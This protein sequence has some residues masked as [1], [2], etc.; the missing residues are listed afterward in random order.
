MKFPVAVLAVLAIASVANGADPSVRPPTDAA[1]LHFGGSTAKAAVDT[2]VLMGPGSRYPYSG[3]F[4]TI[5]PRPLSQGFLAD[6]WVSRDLNALPG[7]HWH[8]D[9][10]GNP[11]TGYGVWCGTLSFPSC[12]GSDPSG[13]YGNNWHDVLEF[14]KPV[15]GAATVRVQAKLRY[16]TEPGYDFLSLK[17]RT[18]NAP[19]FESVAGGQ[20]QAWDGQ[21]TV[22][23]DR[24]FTYTNAELVGGT[25]IAIAFI[26]D[27]ESGWSDEDCY[28]PTAGAAA[29]DDITVT[30]DDGNVTVYHKDFEDGQVGPDWNLAPDRVGVGDFARVWTRL[31]DLDPCVGNPTNQVAFLDDGLVVP[32]TGG[33]VGMAGNDYGTP[34]GWTVNGTGGMLGHGHDLR[35]V[36]ESPVMTLPGGDIDGVTLSFDVY[37][38]EWQTQD[39]AMISY[40]WSIRS[41]AGGD[42]S[43]AAWVDRG[44]LPV[45]G[46]AYRRSVNPVGDLLVP[47]ATQLQVRLAVWQQCAMFFCLGTEATPAPYF[48]NVRVV[49]YPS[50]GPRI[51]AR[52]EDLANDGFPAIGA[53]DLADPGRNSVRFDMADNIAYPPRMLIDPG[54]SICVDVT[55]RSGATLDAPVLHWTLA[56]R[57]PLFDA[58]RT[59][60]ENPVTGRVT[61][62][63]RGHL[64][65][66]R[67]NFDLPD[68]GMLFPGDVLQ[69][70]IAA[71]D[72]AGG[73]T[74]T[75]TLP[76]DLAGYGDPKPQGYPGLCTVRCLPT[77]LDA[78][79]TQPSLL[80]WNDQGFR[81]GEDV[82]YGALR[83][84][85][86]SEGLDYDV[87][88]THAPTSHAGNGLAG[89]ATVAQIAGYADMLYTSGDLSSSTLSNGDFYRDDA[90]DDIGL[91]DAWFASGGRDMFLSGDDLAYSLY[92]GG[93]AG[94]DFVT[95]KMG[96]AVHATDVK[97]ELDGQDSPGVV[98]I[99]GN[100]VFPSL[101][102]WTAYGGCPQPND[103]DAVTVLD[104]AVRL[105]QFAAPGGGTTPYPYAAAVLNTSGTNRVISTCCDL[106]S[107]VDAAKSPA[108][109]PARDV[110]LGAA[111]A[112]FGAAGA[113]APAGTGMPAAALD[114]AVFPNPFNPTVTLR[115]TL[116]RPA[117]LS[118]KV[119]DARGALVRTLVDGRVDQV[120]GEVVWD[121]VDDVGGAVPSGIYFVETR[122]G[123][124]VD[125]RKVTLV[126]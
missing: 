82:W 30:V 2:I 25:D 106:M 101:N 68:T 75:T 104:G 94:R 43:T 114:V 49:A 35:N 44:G 97:G 20:G 56:R 95:S 6:G 54:D 34:E 66:N 14:R 29:V 100:P 113:G 81:G 33:T 41:T 93:G 17:R 40:R 3:D 121:G 36:V 98:T 27:S 60:P 74:R 48:D 10:Y 7:N 87:Y 73:D 118:L 11:G 103:F 31:G 45:G 5:L 80:F 90:C 9:T 69:Y 77:M 116:P 84:L 50:A 123:A 120:R 102:G 124:Q 57:N 105:A 85:G 19:D 63:S 67:W 28:W 23:V 26:F 62:D 79:G 24:V 83:R 12:D 92:Q 119:F 22:V 108:P 53:I 126:K 58:F 89:R 107:I 70:Y 47:G 99:A 37:V 110:L 18:A 46:P 76:A 112:F 4:E 16:D 39:S 55:P 52:E 122:A 115:W 51:V 71:T 59:L 32:G 72:H 86:L 65:A 15:A 8:V 91:L 78:A 38:H 109:L 125:V 61:R 13:G 1:S 96:I 64:I 88:T 117:D 42:I 111:L 21:G